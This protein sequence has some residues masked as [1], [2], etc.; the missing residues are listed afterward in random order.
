MV[1]AAGV[2]LL[3][4]CPKE[5][6][7]PPP[8]PP[9]PPPLTESTLPPTGAPDFHIDFEIQHGD[10]PKQL[11]VAGSVRNTG[12]RATRELKVWVEAV[13]GAGTRVLPPREFYPEDQE[14]AP[15]GI[16]RFRV[17]LPNDPA[18]RTVRVEAYGK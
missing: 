15:G 5:P 14:V 7:P 3:A 10:D 6:P 16:A 8:A 17:F 2:L 11:I 1:V 12:S 13:D 4:G 18:I 9:P